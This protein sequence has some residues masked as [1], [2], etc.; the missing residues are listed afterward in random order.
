MRLAARFLPAAALAL[1]AVSCAGPAKLAQQSDEALAKGDVRKAYDRALRAVEKDPMNAAARAAYDAASNRVAADYRQRVLAAAAADTMAAA[2]LVLTFRNFRYEVAEHGSQLA[3]DL[4]FDARERRIVAT[5]ARECYRLGRA[6]MEAGRPRSAWMHFTDCR[7]FDDGYADVA[8]R[9]DAAYTAAV[10]RVAVLPFVDGIGIPG[11]SQTIGSEAIAQIGRRAEQQFRFTQILDDATVQGKMTLAQIR[12]L[13]REGAIEL[14]RKLG[15]QRIV[16]GHFSGIRTNNDMKDLTIPIYHRTVG[17]D[18][19][20]HD[21]ERWEESS[22][23][24]VT[25][26]RQVTVQYD[27]D[28]IDVRTGEVLLHKQLPA[29]TAARV[30]WT[31][32]RPAEDCDHYALL[33]P[34]VRKA[35]PDRARKLDEQWSDRV[36]SWQLKDLLVK[37]RDERSRANYNSRYRGEFLNNTRSR[38]VWLGELPR[39]DD[40]AFCALNELWRPVNDALKELD[41]KD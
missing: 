16:L 38:P 33:P 28:V 8:K 20:G 17:K 35:Q 18:P 25:R 6:D 9:Q 32:F 31:D 2:N 10:T 39:E 15:A 14:G 30:V 5:A 11:L 26:E 41:T 22:L 21:I 7:R 40:L 34:D 4:E 19:D 1:L 23:R 12:D 27:F 37:A 3:A 13:S 29:E 36:G 24:V